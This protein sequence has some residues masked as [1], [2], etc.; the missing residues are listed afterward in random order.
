MASQW[1]ALPGSG[2]QLVSSWPSTK[3]VCVSRS[4]PSLEA[5]R[6]MIRCG[7]PGGADRDRT[8]DL[9]LAKPALS[10]LSYSP[11]ELPGRDPFACPPSHPHR[12][13]CRGAVVGL[14]GFE[15]PTS[16]LSGGRS[17]QLS[18]RPSRYLARTRGR[19]GTTC[20]GLQKLNSVG[21]GRANGQKTSRLNEL[22][23]E[24]GIQAFLIAT[25]LTK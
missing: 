18:Y 17:N 22:P 8:D 23:G 2:Y 19:L 12:S 25:K 20:S 6:E 4:S 21:G 3:D 10:Q 1:I 11:E 24:P 13:R 14:G 16:R 5:G 15:P 7:V 9:R